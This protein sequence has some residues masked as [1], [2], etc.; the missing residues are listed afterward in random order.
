[1]LISDALLG[2]HNHTDGQRLIQR[3][4]GEVSDSCR[5][6]P[7]SVP[8]P[9]IVPPANACYPAT[10]LS[11]RLQPVPEVMEQATTEL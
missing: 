8:R 6:I 11:G 1:M 7:P 4:E 9:Y 2:Q 10:M 3:H 5:R